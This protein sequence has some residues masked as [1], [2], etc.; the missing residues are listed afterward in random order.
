MPGQSLDRADPDRAAPYIRQPDENLAP[1]C[2]SDVTEA[3][4]LLRIRC[5]LLRGEGQEGVVF[6]FW[7]QNT[8]SITSHIARVMIDEGGCCGVP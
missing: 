2:A 4:H 5:H 1:S 3:A 8:E 6:V 7:A